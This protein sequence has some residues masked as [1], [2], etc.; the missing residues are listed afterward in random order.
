MFELSESTIDATAMK[1][2]IAN[3]QA[4]ACV[5]FDGWVR[6]HNEGKE[7]LRLEYEAYA[8]LALSEGQKIIAEAREKFGLLEARAIHRVGALEIGDIA[9]WVGVSTAHRGESFDACRYIIDEVKHRLPI[10]KKEHYTDGD[11]GWVNCERCAAAH[12]ERDA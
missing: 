9:V 12:A 5:T 1:E 3:P 7:V 6:N 4:G 2:S 10:W 8:A 11:S